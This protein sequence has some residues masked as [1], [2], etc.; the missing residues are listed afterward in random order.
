[1]QTEGVFENMVLKK[2]FGPK[3]NEV[4]AGCRRM[5]NE[6][7]YNLHSSPNTTLIKSRWMRWARHMVH[8]GKK[9]NACRV[10][11]RKRGGNRSI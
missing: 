7:H 1:M 9:R 11:V 2:S 8:M 5:H 4:T 3:G 10:F 6:E